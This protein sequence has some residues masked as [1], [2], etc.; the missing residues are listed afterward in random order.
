MLKPSQYRVSGM[1]KPALFCIDLIGGILTWPFRKNAPIDQSSIKKILLIRLDNIGDVLVTTPSVRALRKK[2]PDAEIHILVRPSTA[3]LVIHNPNL[4]Q[5]IQFEPPWLHRSGALR[6]WDSLLT[7]KD[8]A[9]IRRLREEKYDLIIEFHTEPRNIILS[10]A[11]KGR[12]RVGHADRGLGF[13]LT[14]Q[15]PYEDS[16]HIM[17]RTQRLVEYAGC[18]AEMPMLDLFLSHADEANGQK[19]MKEHWLRK[20]EFICLNPG[21]GRV[22]KRWTNQCWTELADLIHDKHNATIV[23]TGSSDDLPDIYQIISGMRNG[24]TAVVLA[25]KTTL[26]GLA[27]VYRHAK[28]VVCPDTGPLHIAKSVGAPLVAL[29]GPINPIIWGYNDD[30][31]RTVI[32]KQPCSFCDKPDCILKKDRYVCMTSITTKEIMHELKYVLRSV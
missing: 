15:V 5:V 11:A 3:G 19:A 14:H 2:Y 23:F 12:Y 29:F 10:W 18:A 20:K 21:T 9:T 1:F 28:A 16:G 13:L 30:N 24:Q 4:N 8:N 32:R 17:D 6:L 31:S 27:E 26:G 22:N 25:G 7:F